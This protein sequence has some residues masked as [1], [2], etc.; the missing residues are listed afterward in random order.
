[1]N[2]HLKLAIEAMAEVEKLAAEKETE[3]MNFVVSFASAHAAIA[4]AEAMEKI[5]A[6]FDSVIEKVGGSPSISTFD[7]YQ[8]W[9]E[10]L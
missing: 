3:A 8:T 9:K 4:Q 5:A 10:N 1:M 6:L 2:E 7:S